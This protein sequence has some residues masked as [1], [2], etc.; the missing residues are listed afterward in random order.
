MPARRKSKSRS[1]SPRRVR[2]SSGRKAR[3]SVTQ[4][5]SPKRTYKG[6]DARLY[7]MQSTDSP[8]AHVELPLPQ[9]TSAQM[10]I[11]TFLE[12]NGI[13][14]EL[15]ADGFHVDGTQFPLQTLKDAN[16][17][18]LRAKARQPPHDT[19]RV[20]EIL[21]NLGF[22]KYAINYDSITVAPRA[23]LPLIDVRPTPNVKNGL[24]VIGYH[25]GT[26]TGLER[27]DLATAFKTVLFLQEK[28]YEADVPLYLD[29][30]G[31]SGT[32]MVQYPEPPKPGVLTKLLGAKK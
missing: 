29:K 28:C 8:P 2:R 23:D 22:L 4:R 6:V 20:V 5:R 1:K 11:G 7:G 27:P 14:Y 12:T 25:F 3:T 18:V 31:L 16:I 9:M 19:T 13:T 15:N 21:T 10:E 32:G 17:A 24:A 30:I 26:G